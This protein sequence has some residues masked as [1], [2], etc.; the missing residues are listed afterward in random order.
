MDVGVNV[1]VGV[2][3]GRQASRHATGNIAVD[4]M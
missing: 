1:M 4:E 3:A 2:V